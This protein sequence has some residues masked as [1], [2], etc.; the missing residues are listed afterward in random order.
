MRA[1]PLIR[2]LLLPALGILLG[3]LPYFS[4]A[5][6]E[7]AYIIP[8][9]AARGRTLVT[10][11]VGEVEV[12]RILLDSGMPFDG[13]MIYNPAYADSLDLTNAIDVKIPG[14]GGGDASNG[15]ML[16]SAVFT[17]GNLEMTNQRIILLKSDAYK[18]FPTNGII[19]YSIFGHYATELDYDKSVMILHDA[20]SLRADSTWTTIPMYFK[21]NN[22]PWIDVLIAT[23]DEAPVLVSAYIDYA[24][25]DAI[26]LLERPEMKFALPRETKKAHLGRGLSGDIYGKTGR[27]SRLII[28]GYELTDVPAA[29]A[30]AAVRS[31]QKDA[32]AILG[33]GSLSKFN[34]IFDYAGKRLYIKPNASFK[35][36]FE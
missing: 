30:P 23:E 5:A 2:P 9:E 15:A 28:G 19:G 22:I 8:I 36:P 25:G 10:V 33:N 1:S 18:G 21:D 31:K 13:V 34:L 26:E 14:A 11:R 35:K 17:V 3:I 12:P 27:I 32:D 4:Y 16:D 7:A 24:S 29:I 20:D 6:G